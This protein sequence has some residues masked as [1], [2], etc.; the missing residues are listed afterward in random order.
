MI[1]PDYGS[2][3]VISGTEAGL[4]SKAAPVCAPE[5]IEHLGSVKVLGQSAASNIP[6]HE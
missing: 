1:N 4:D 6:R 2:E 5:L 3:L